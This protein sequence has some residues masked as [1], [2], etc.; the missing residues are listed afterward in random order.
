MQITLKRNVVL[1]VGQPF[2]S[3]IDVDVKTD[4]DT[5]THTCVHAHVWK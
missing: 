4:E 1:K 2:R 3:T 5:D